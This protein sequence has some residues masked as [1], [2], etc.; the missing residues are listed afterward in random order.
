MDRRFKFLICTAGIFIT[1]FYYGI[2]QEK[3]T[4][5][6]YGGEQFTC[7]L[8][9]VFIQCIANYFYAIFTSVTV[10]KQGEDTTRTSYYVSC[11][12]TYVVAMLCSNL[13]LKWVNYP[14]QVIGKS[15]KPI[16]VMILSV[17]FGKKT[18]PFK[19][20]CFVLL[21]VMGVGL[22]MYK[23]NKSSASDSIFGYGEMMILFSLLMDG[24]TAAIQ[25][26]MRSE[27]KTKSGHLMIN[28]NKWS[29]LFLG[30]GVLCTGE[31]LTFIDFVKRHPA[32]LW[33]LISFSAASAFGQ[34]FIF[35]T[36]SDFGPLPC[37]IITTTRKFFTVLASVIIF[38]NIMLPRQ[39]FAT[40]LVFTG[41]FL[42]GVF[43]KAG[44]PVE[45]T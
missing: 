45:K 2:I 8:S 24:L 30:A 34:F 20:Y 33:E 26:R 40:L 14:T 43:G 23:D 25:E 27:S 4:R 39:W 19:K 32:V 16:P 41:L 15:A 1:Y 18:Y 12:L 31:F 17:L 7:M 10:M 9:L 35:L 29:I 6:N 3:I 44:K 11:A 42:D 36:V 28:M 37:S 22:F 38:G 21:V 5:G 13:A